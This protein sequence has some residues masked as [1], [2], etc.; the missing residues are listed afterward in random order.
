MKLWPDLGLMV[1]ELRLQGYMV[2]AVVTNR[3]TGPMMMA[4]AR[5]H[6]KNRSVASGHIARARLMLEVL[7]DPEGP[8][9][10]MY[11]LQYEQLVADPVK[12]IQALVDLA[13]L[14]NVDVKGIVD[15]VGIYDGNAPYGDE[16]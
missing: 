14:I 16:S 11:R 7:D 3:E 9:M 13:G 6:V 2:S 5:D 1:R 4:Q 10:P 15:E 12:T 8:G